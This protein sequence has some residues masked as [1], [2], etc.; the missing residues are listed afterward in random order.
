MQRTLVPAVSAAASLI[1]VFIAC[2]AAGNEQLQLAQ[3]VSQHLGCVRRQELCAAGARSSRSARDL[4]RLLQRLRDLR[5][6][7]CAL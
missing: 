4:K 7:R 1:I 2:H 5:A 3:L 6:R